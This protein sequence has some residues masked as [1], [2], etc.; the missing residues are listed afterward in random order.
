MGFMDKISK[1]FNY[2]EDIENNEEGTVSDAPVTSKRNRGS[3][4][5]TTAQNEFV[6]VR[7]ER[8]DECLQIGSYL[9]EKKT[10]VLNLETTGK[11]S[12]RRIVDFLSGVAFALS[13]TIKK[14]SLATYLITPSN[15]EITGESM[16]DIENSGMFF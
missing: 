15:A 16:D 8:Y 10:V 5:S 3:D 6:V 11:D 7:P 14:V 4:F 13:G 1:V 9:L 2:D 12:A